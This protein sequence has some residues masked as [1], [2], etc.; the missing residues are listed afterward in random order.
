MLHTL[1]NL[2]ENKRPIGMA[3]GRPE[4]RHRLI[5]VW[6]NAISEIITV[7]PHTTGIAAAVNKK[8]IGH[9]NKR[10]KNEKPQQ[11]QRLIYMKAKTEPKRFVLFNPGAKSSLKRQATTAQLTL[12]RLGIILRSTNLVEPRTSRRTRRTLG[13]RTSPRVVSAAT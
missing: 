7:G 3:F 2:A 13:L 4:N 9:V 6:G 12:S 10:S 8:S 11:L 1:R 5:F